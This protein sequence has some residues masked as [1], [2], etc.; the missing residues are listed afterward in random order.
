MEGSFK[1]L[2]IAVIESNEQTRAPEQGDRHGTLGSLF[3]NALVA[4]GPT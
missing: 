1:I 4:A 3:H 2:P